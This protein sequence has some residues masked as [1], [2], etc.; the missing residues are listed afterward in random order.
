MALKGTQGPQETSGKFKVFQ[1]SE[2]RKSTRNEIFRELQ[3]TPEKFH[4]L[5]GPQITPG[6]QRIYKEFQRTKL[7]F[8]V[9]QETVKNSKENLGVGISI[10]L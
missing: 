5:K 8:R 4:E 1:G 2:L 10:E 7:R 6:I 9:Y 3:K